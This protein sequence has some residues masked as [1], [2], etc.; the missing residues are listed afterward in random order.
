[1]TAIP[2]YIFGKRCRSWT[3]RVEIFQKVMRAWGLCSI[4]YGWSLHTLLI[5]FFIL[6][7]PGI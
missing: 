2:M 5:W 7:R 1:L 3:S 4:Y 6:F